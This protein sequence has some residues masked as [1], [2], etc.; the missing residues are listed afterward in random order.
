MNLFKKNDSISLVSCSNGLDISMRD[1]INELK[2][3]LKQLNLNVFESEALYKD[4]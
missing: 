4:E 3:I 2:Y 1:K